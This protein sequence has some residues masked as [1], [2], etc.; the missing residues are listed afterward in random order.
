MSNVIINDGKGNEYQLTAAKPPIHAK[1][2]EKQLPAGSKPAKQQWADAWK[3]LFPGKPCPPTNDKIIQAINAAL[4]KTLL[5]T[6]AAAS[7]QAK[8]GNAARVVK[9][10][11]KGASGGAGASETLVPAQS[12]QPHQV[13]PDANAPISDK[14]AVSQAKPGKTSPE[15]TTGSA[16]SAST[17]KLGCPISM[18]SGEELL[19]LADFTLP[20]PLPFTWK[21]TYRTSHDR[22]IGLGHGWTHSGCERLYETDSE[23]ELQDDE[24]RLL[25][26][27]RPRLNQRSKLINEQMA[28]D[29]INYDTYILRQHG[30]PHKVFS[31]LGQTGLFRLVQIQH[32]AFKAA[33]GSDS[34]QGFFLDF[35]YN[36]QGR[37]S[38]IAGNWGKSLQFSQDEQGHIRSI[39]LCN[40]LKNT[41]LLVAEYDYSADNDLIAQ[42]DKAGRGETYRYHNHL[43]TQR[44]L[45]TGFS[46]YYTWDGE[47]TRAR[48]LRTWGD[49]GIYDYHFVWD[50]DNNRTIA[51]DS[52]GFTSEF[53]YNEFGLIVQETD[54]EGGVHRYTYEN[55]LRTGHIDP[56]GNLTRYFY[57]GNNHFSGTADALD[58]RQTLSWFQD[59]LTASTDKDGA[60]WQRSYNAKG[61]LETLTAP[62]GQVTRYQYNAQGLLSAQTDVLGTTR[63]EWNDAG[64]L[65]ALINPEGHKQAFKYDDLG[66]I[67]Q[68][69]LWLASRQHGGTTRYFYNASNELIRT[70]YPT[71]ERVDITYNANGQIERLSDRRGRVT[72]YHYDGLSQVVRR[73]DPEGN[74]LNYEYDTERNLV[75]LTNENGDD[76]QFFYDGNERLIKEI[77]FDGRTQHYK[78][79]PAGHLI[80]HLDAGEVVTEFE[81]D[82]LGRMLSKTSRALSD[83]SNTSEFSRYLYDPV[84]RLKETY[85][86]HQYLAFHYDARGRLIGEHHSDL[87]AQRQRIS[88]SMVDIHFQRYATGQLK[89]LQLPHSQ[90]IDY[91]YDNNHRLHKTFINGQAIASIERDALGF[92]RNRQ[93]GA[94][95]TYSDYDPMGRLIKQRAEHQQQRSGVIQRE[96]QYDPFGNL[97]V[98]KD[99]IGSENTWEVRYVYDMVDRLKRTEGDLSE[100][101]V[102]DPAGNL[103]AQQKKSTG[104]TARGNRLLMQ[105]D[106]K[107]E[108]DARGN[109]VRETR[110]KGGKLETRFE[111]NFNNQLCKVIK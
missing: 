96:Y 55:G 88:D 69:D 26:F 84:G 53:I 62:D 108:Y 104:K 89:K 81:R 65:V 91:L 107:F 10:G 101:F 110:G 70:L 93:Q 7:P 94:L 63:Y 1:D 56:A 102:F 109:L 27:A 22:D 103:L 32:P 11:S 64:E 9:T 28:L 13:Q 87:N 86:G 40:E 41:R 54:N 33:A 44:T 17:C 46:Y 30:Q 43:F 38:K 67:V 57:D 100:N 60:L 15:A 5:L 25:S 90:T 74:S 77:G 76:Y 50:A 6:R 99:G 52:R 85:N 73:T 18:V 3:T 14:N 4:G 21:R 66:Q 12:V 16:A 37:I 82:P 97:S 48:C 58:Q 106:R 59:R 19:D 111:Y 29:Y 78:Y 92:E 95:T 105:G 36:T 24:G 83:N 72:H 49:K 51:T 23:L 75:R 61:L 39:T 98:F 80:K 42:R 20:G 8:T 79:N 45:A 47:D 31:R 34:A 2:T 35:H 68:M 71:G